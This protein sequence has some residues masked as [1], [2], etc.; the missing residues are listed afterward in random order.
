MPR[1][2]PSSK[3]H[4]LEQ[5]AYFARIHLRDGLEEDRRIL[6]TLVN[7]A[8]P[9]DKPVDPDTSPIVRSDGRTVPVSVPVDIVPGILHYLTSDN[10]NACGVAVANAVYTASLVNCAAC[11]RWMNGGK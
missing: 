1:G 5:I 4:E 8:F 7:N 2:V 11:L 3:R 10:R 6:I 9:Y